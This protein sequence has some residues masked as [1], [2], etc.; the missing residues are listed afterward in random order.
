LELL[1][2]NRMKELI[3]GLRQSYDRIIIDSPPLMIFSDALVLSRLA[4]G[5]ILIVWGGKTSR[6]VVRNG[7]Q[8]LAATNAKMLG[9]VLNNVKVTKRNSYYYYSYHNYYYGEKG[10][11]K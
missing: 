4:D 1:G 8:S 7:G 3:A 9:V 10:T 11:K 6:D 5:T 2:S